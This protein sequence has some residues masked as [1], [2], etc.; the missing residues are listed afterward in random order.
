LR[1]QPKRLFKGIGDVPPTSERQLFVQKSTARHFAK[2]RFNTIEDGAARRAVKKI[3]QNIT[4]LL[5][6]KII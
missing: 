6:N 1:S 4:Y 3:L 5:K 2:T